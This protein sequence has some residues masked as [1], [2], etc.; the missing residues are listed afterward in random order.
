MGKKDK[1]LR[2]R[3]TRERKVAKKKVQDRE[4]KRIQD[5]QAVFEQVRALLKEDREPSRNDEQA[6]DEEEIS[7]LELERFQRYLWKAALK[8]GYDPDALTDTQELE[9]IEDWEA[10]REQLLAEDPVEEAQDIMYQALEEAN[11][12]DFDDWQT[13]EK[14]QK[15]L[16]RDALELDP[17]NIDALTLQAKFAFDHVKDDD[18][19]G[20]RLLNEAVCKAREALGPDF[21][22]RNRSSLYLRVE[23]KPFLRALSALAE[24]YDGELRFAEAHS[25]LQ[26]LIGYLPPV[27]THFRRMHLAAAFCFGKADEVRQTITKGEFADSLIRPWAECLL[28][29][30]E[31]RDESAIAHLDIALVES[32]YFPISLL[33]LDEEDA[34]EAEDISSD[35]STQ[36]DR[37]QGKRVDLVLGRA[38]R[39]VPGAR[40][41]LRV[42]WVRRFIPNSKN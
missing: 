42:Q 2:K 7:P 18:V 14:A 12:A 10:R 41:W 39:N 37:D 15:A 3:K 38:W 27:E 24:Y 30:V 13:S 34:E 26:E 33:D 5:K 32:P 1:E 29:F 28:A 16:A 22:Q 36:T 31:G 17:T 21:L 25:P 9:L 8:A 40:E 35:G 11:E 6:G 23:A 19:T 20:F 4:T